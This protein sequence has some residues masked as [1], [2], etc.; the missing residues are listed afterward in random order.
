MIWFQTNVLFYQAKPKLNT[1]IDDLFHP[2][3][4]KTRGHLV[5]T[6][7]WDLQVKAHNFQKEKLTEDQNN[8]KRN[9][10]RRP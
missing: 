5:P 9:K 8:E 2:Q 4:E 3:P 1:T 6:A 10:P 7:D